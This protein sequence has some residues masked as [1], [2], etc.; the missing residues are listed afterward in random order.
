MDKLH[1]HF[2]TKF[3][4]TITFLQ[5]TWLNALERLMQHDYCLLYDHGLPLVHRQAIETRIPKAKRMELAGG[6]ASKSLQEMQTI[7]TWFDQTGVHPKTTIIVV[8]GGAML[9]A[10]G[11]ISSI[12]LRGLPLVYVPTTLLAMVD[13]S[14][15]GKTALN[16]NAKNQLG[17]FYPAKEIFIDTEFLRTLPIQLYQEGMA[18]IIKIALVL[19]ANFVE[20]LKLKRLDIEAMILWAVRL[21][22]ALVEQDLLDQGDRR[23]LNFGHTFGHALE[24]ALAYRVSHGRC[25]AEGMLIETEGSRFYD[26][27]HTLLSLYGILTPIEYNRDA[28]LPFVHYDK[29]RDEAMLEVVELVSL[30]RAIRQRYPLQDMLT[31]WQERK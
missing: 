9:D 27:V 19:D 17:S 1:A 11:F 16:I 2:T 31:R 18:E 7:L 20:A 8:G 26:D 30:G 28:V 13:A 14:I 6:E 25:V 24:V 12:Y 4:T 22:L 5:G 21:K 10:V 23:L 29:K 15:G 3:S